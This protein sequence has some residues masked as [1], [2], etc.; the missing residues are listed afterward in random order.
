MVAIR[1]YQ[2]P[3]SNKDHPVETEGETEGEKS[4]SE[5]ET[6]DEEEAV[7][8]AGKQEDERKKKG[9]RKEEICLEG[10]TDEIQDMLMVGVDLYCTD[11]YSVLAQIMQEAFQ[12]P[13]ATLRALFDASGA[14]INK[15]I[16]SSE[17]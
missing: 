9:S 16:M 8:G 10:L 15:F 5:T 2:P 17:Q 13:L 3:G 11:P 12:C 6:G 7:D 14:D 4:R 1:S